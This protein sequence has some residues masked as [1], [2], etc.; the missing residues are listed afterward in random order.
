MSDSDTTPRNVQNLLR[1]KIFNAIPK[2]T[3][4]RLWQG[5]VSAANKGIARFL[6]TVRKQC[7]SFT[8][9]VRYSRLDWRVCKESSGSWE[10]SL[11]MT[12]S[13]RIVSQPFFRVNEFPADRGSAL[14]ECCWLGPNPLFHAQILFCST[15]AQSLHNSRLSGLPDVR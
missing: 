2:D 9:L 8:K 7:P 4:E 5:Q 13:E 6:G 3:T 10:F 14:L 11:Q 15:F 12:K 1:V